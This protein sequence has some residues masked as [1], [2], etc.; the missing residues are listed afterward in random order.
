[1]MK[2]LVD[3]CDFLIVADELNQNVTLEQINK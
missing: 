3:F 2:K 1:M